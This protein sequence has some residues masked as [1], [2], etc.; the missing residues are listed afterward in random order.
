MAFIIAG[1]GSEVTLDDQLVE[2]VVRYA[3]RMAELAASELACLQVQTGTDLQFPRGFTLELAALAQLRIWEHDGL[4]GYFRNALPDYASAKAELIAR[5]R[6]TPK[7]LWETEHAVLSQRVLRFW[8]SRF[9]WDS[10][11][12]LGAE[13]VCSDLDEAAFVKALA[14]VLWD[15][16]E[17]LTKLATNA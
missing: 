13:M 9:A 1:D 16:R 3:E 5:M 2:H 15:N 11:E 6:D 10:Q 4:A 14:Q 8:M 7:S 17:H 12:H